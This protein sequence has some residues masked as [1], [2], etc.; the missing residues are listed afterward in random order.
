M[1]KKNIFII[2]IVM[3]SSIL[4]LIS[5][6]TFD[7]RQQ[8]LFFESNDLYTQNHVFVKD[9]LEMI[10]T[11]TFQDVPDLSVFLTMESENDDQVRAYTAK[12]YGSQQFPI[13]KGN[14]FKKAD[15]KVTW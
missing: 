7:K 12:D 2:F 9:N 6:G 4:L 10:L 14:F 1:T 3:C 5:V 13:S 11:K 15:S 8:N